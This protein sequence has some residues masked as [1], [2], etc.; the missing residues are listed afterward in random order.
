MLVRAWGK[1]MLTGCLLMSMSYI[2]FLCPLGWMMS[3]S[4]FPLSRHLWGFNTS[5]L[6]TVVV[7]LFYKFYVS[8]WKVM[9]DTNKLFYVHL[10]VLGLKL[11]FSMTKGKSGLL[12]LMWASFRQWKIQVED[13][14]WYSYPQGRESCSCLLWLQAETLYYCFC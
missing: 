7:S 1:V 3:P 14:N 6:T 13:E 5:F 11:T 9:R 2:M 10:C 4:S 8:A 12:S